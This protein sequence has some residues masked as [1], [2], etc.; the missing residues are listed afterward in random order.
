MISLKDSEKENGAFM[1]SGIKLWKIQNGNQL[2]QI[3]D[4]ELNLEERLEDWIE[5]DI[6]MLSDNE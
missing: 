2:K 1:T 4:S 6:S 5:D 3:E